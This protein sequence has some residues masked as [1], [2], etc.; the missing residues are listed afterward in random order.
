MR[1]HQLCGYHLGS[2]VSAKGSPT[3]DSSG[4]RSSN[5]TA[6]PQIDIEL[7]QH[8]LPNLPRDGTVATAAGLMTGT[9]AVR[10]SLDN[11]PAVLLID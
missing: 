5:A 6:L 10:S 8:L 4:F 1:A 11:A 2:S 9:D 7:W 3:P